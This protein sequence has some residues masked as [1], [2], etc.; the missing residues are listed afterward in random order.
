MSIIVDI[1]DLADAVAD[2][3]W[4]YLLTVGP[5][6]DVHVLAV[7]R[8]YEGGVF[9]VEAGRT[10]RANATSRPEVTLVFPP[11]G[12][13]GRDAM[14]IIVDGTASVHDDRLAIEPRAAVLHRAA[15]VA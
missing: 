2:R 14:S 8:H 1:P 10:A 5:D 9:A 12:A 4:G 3:R 6:L 7:A 11:V 15:P 13:D